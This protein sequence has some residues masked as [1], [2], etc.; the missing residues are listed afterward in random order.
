M[1]N[2]KV[3]SKPILVLMLSILASIVSAADI[4]AESERSEADAARDVTSKPYEVLK[5]FGVQPGW[6]VLDVLAGTGYYSEV[7]SQ[8]V[9]S[10]GK[11]YLHNNGAYIRFAQG[12][13]ARVADDRLP[14]V[15]A[16]VEEVDAMSIAAGSLDMAILVMTYHDAYFTSTGWTL[17]PD[18]LFATLRRVLK[19]GGV[20][21]IVDHHG[22]PGTGI[23]QVQQLHRI[24]AAFAKADIAGRG[25]TF[26]GG[27]DILENLDDDLT[28]GVFDPAIRRKTSRFVYKF[29]RE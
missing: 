23:A 5:F 16:I 1:A 18:P 3:A 14:N 17:T 11:V 6:K 29:V 25:F 19:P 4:R 27:S 20:L 26:V 28:K 2:L 15:E 24:D 9:G 8:V 12:L 7:M 10:E 13:D 21:A 22:Q